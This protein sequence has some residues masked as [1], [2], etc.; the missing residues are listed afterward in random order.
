MY[1]GDV[2]PAS[3]STT[4]SWVTQ[5]LDIGK[6]ALQLKQQS[7]LQKINVDRLRQGLPALDT[8]DVAAQV[9]VGMDTAQLNKILLAGGAVALLIT[10]LVLMRRRR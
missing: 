9:K 5:L 10:A 4:P 8:G 6:G 2:T 1:L 3:T 7:D